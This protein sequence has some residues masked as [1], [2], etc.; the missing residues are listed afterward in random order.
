[1]NA[2]VSLSHPLWIAVLAGSALALVACSSAGSGTR[3]GS[4][5]PP[6]DVLLHPGAY[7]ADGFTFSKDQPAR[8]PNAFE[9]YFKRCSANDRKSYWSKTS[10]D[11]T[12]P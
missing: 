2:E 8:S 7:A 9:F 12:L 11:C 4:E 5:P 10:Y 6:P 3:F 1:M